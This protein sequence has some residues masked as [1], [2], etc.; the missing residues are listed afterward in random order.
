MCLFNKCFCHFK[1]SIE[2]NLFTAL[3]SGVGF[4]CFYCFV[5]GVR[6]RV[7]LGSPS[8]SG[9]HCVAQ[10]GL[11]FVAILLPEP[12]KARMTGV[13]HYVQLLQLDSNQYLLGSYEAKP[14]DIQNA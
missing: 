8:W 14:H 3:G 9:A 5:V 10:S 12:P 11:G 6:D 13:S 2:Q 7:L 1:Y 4:C